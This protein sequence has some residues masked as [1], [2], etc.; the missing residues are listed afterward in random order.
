M[1]HA[2]TFSFKGLKCLVKTVSELF[3]CVQI[4]LQCAD[5][6]AVLHEVNI[7]VYMHVLKTSV[8]LKSAFTEKENLIFWRLFLLL[9]YLCLVSPLQE[10]YELLIFF[11]PLENKLYALLSVCYQRYEVFTV[12]KF[13]MLVF[14]VVMPVWLQVV[15]RY[16]TWS[17]RYE[18]GIFLSR[19]TFKF[20]HC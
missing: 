14:R 15:T 13:S 19:D 4:L 3:G 17:Y 7:D 1:L 11:L 16:H 10:H 8:R 18:L 6:T 20:Q 5:S 2:L 9:S 12:V